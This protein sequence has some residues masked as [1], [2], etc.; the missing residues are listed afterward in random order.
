MQGAVINVVTRQGSDRF[1]YDASYYG[2]AAALTSQPVHLAYPGAGQPTSGYERDRYNDATTN[3]GGPVLRD[4][5]WFFGGYQYLPRLRQSAGDRPRLPED[6]RAGQDLRKAHVANHSR[7]AAGAKLSRRALGQP[8]A[9]D[10][11]EAVRGDPA[12]ARES[13]GHDLRPPDAHDVIQHGLGCACRPLRLQPRRRPEHGEPDD[14]EPDRARHQRPERRA[15]D[16]RRPH[17]ETDDGERHPEPLPAA[18]PGCQSS[19]A[20]RRPAREGRA[21][22]VVDHSDRYQVCR[23]RRTAV[24]S[25][26]ERSLHRGRPVHHHRRVRQRRHHRGQPADDQRRTAVRPQP[27]HQ[28]G[29]ADAR[30]RGA[31]NRRR[32]E[33]SRRLVYVERL[34]AASGGHHA[35]HRRRPHDA[36]GELRAVQ[37]G[38]ADGGAG[39]IPSRRDP[40][41]HRYVRPGDRRLHEQHHR[42]RSE[43]EPAVRSRDADAAHRR[44][45]RRRRS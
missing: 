34:V 10:I 16:V 30:C 12:P 25:D 40:D 2:Q 37:S 22:A 4:R 14:A 15:A 6:L 41:H 28:P 43:K 19:V 39:A 26:V 31:R 5:L 24:S 11:D 20:D 18:A 33:R 9:A 27:R 35:A 3:L 36:A 42:G 44:V 21:R 13:A 17:P 32:R 7:L 29:S 38:R 1:L 8:R 45:L 23:P